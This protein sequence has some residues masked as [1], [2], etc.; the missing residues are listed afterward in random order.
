MRHTI[1]K[2]LHEFNERQ[3]VH[4]RDLGLSGPDPHRAYVQC[5]VPCE[6]TGGGTVVFEVFIKNMCNLAQEESKAK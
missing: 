3:G 1:V 5:L 6:I 2:R 4:S